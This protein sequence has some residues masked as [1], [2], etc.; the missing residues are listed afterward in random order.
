[1]LIL[2]KTPS[3]KLKLT[4]LS[5]TRAGENDDA[6]CAV[7]GGGHSE[8]PNCI[9]FC[10]RCDVAVHQA[11]YD[12]D[13]LPQGALPSLRRGP[14]GVCHHRWLVTLLIAGSTPLRLHRS[15]SRCAGCVLGSTSVLPQSGDVK[16]LP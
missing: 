2:T 9:V 15:I 1:V 14:R 6:L 4:L 11:C 7:C 16:V 3:T 13:T 12:L 8:A 5:V 10:D